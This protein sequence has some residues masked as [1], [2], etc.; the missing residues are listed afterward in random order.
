MIY[1]DGPAGFSLDISRVETVSRG[2]RSLLIYDIEFTHASAQG[3]AIK[4][5]DF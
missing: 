4:T 1:R 5:K 3:A 2:E